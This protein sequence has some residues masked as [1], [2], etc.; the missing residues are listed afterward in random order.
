MREPHGQK[1]F[2]FRVKVLE[3]ALPILDKMA[4][5]GL[6]GLGG[7]C[8]ALTS[9]IRHAMIDEWERTAVKK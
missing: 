5:E 1:E 7:R 9:I 8:D 3:N 6:H 2:V 4:K